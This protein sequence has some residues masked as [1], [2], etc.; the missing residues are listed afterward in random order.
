MPLAASIARNKRKTAILTLY[1]LATVL[2]LTWR[3]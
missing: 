1:A 2:L 3:F